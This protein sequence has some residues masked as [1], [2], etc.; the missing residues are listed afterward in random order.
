M[1]T[2]VSQATTVY[3][4]VKKSAVH[5]SDGAVEY[6]CPRHGPMIGNCRPPRHA[7][8][9][10]WCMYFI[11]L[12]AAIP[13]N[14]RGAARDTLL[15]VMLEAQRLSEKGEFDLQ[16][17]RHPQVEIDLTADTPQTPEGAEPLNL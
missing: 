13:S 11:L 9:Y 8:E 4:N 17:D 6:R 14:K 7:C 12:D 15:R 16:I 10:C 3:D 2:R 5:H 1:L